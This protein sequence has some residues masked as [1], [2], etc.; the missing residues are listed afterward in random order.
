ML[1]VVGCWHGLSGCICIE[2]RALLVPVFLYLTA[3]ELAAPDRA[4][5]TLHGTTIE[6]NALPYTASSASWNSTD[7]LRKRI[8]RRRHDSK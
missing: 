4:Y 7:S 8:N 5:L 1:S 2:E 6:P 3:A